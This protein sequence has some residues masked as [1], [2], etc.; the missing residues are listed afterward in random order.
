VDLIL[1]SYKN[2]ESILK[3]NGSRCIIQN[4]IED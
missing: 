3:I 4:K 1:L 2:L